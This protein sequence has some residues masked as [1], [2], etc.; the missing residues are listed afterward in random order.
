MAA[1]AT[2]K[3]MNVG[4]STATTLSAPGY[5]IGGT[6]ITVGSTTNWPTDTGVIFAIDSVTIVNGVEV[7]TAGTYCEFQGTVASG[8]SITN[9]DYVDGSGDQNFAA[10][11]LTRVY[12][13]VSK[14][15][16]NRIVTWGTAEHNQDGTHAAVTATSVNVSGTVTTDTIAEKTAAAGVTIDGMQ[17]KDNLVV[18]ASGKGV[19]NTS[20]NTAAGKLGAAWAS[21]TPTLSGR[22]DDAKWTKTCA[23]IQIGKTVHWRLKLVASTTTPMSGGSTDALFTLPVTAASGYAGSDQTAW[24]G[25]AGFYDNGTAVRGGGVYLSSSSNAI[26][27][28]R[29]HEVSSTYLTPDAI[30]STVPFAWT[31]NDEI[32]ASGTYEAA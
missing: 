18:G 6:S 13:P 29:V 32:T 19:D 30:T 22:F 23:Y 4:L 27:R 1:S 9:V 7:Q 5:T 14:T 12:I 8:T 25:G 17:I 11:A 16:E 28:I 3:L 2:D 10:G 21:W 24:I 31:T 20:L 26:G 15:R